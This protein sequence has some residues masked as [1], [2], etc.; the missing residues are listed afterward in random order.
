MLVERSLRRCR[1][2]GWE[3]HQPP[4]VVRL[5]DRSLDALI[6]RHARTLEVADPEVER[7]VAAVAGS[8]FVIA[9]VSPEG[10]V[11]DTHTDPAF[12]PTAE[13]RNIRIGVDW[14][15]RFQRLSCLQDHAAVLCHF[16]P[17]RSMALSMTRN[18]RMAAV[19]AS[20]L[21]LPATM[22]RW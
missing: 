16:L 13:A 9:I 7:L 18:L 11:L 3:R 21:A 17:S 8:T 22:R 15:E 1:E 19:R 6:Y 2:H 14:N 12:R 20:F 5:D 4:A 10:V